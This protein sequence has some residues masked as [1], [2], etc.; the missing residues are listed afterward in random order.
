MNNTE[1]QEIVWRAGRELYRDMPWRESP[2]PYFVLVS[3]LM[4]QQT[5]VARVIP[6]FQEFIQRFPTLSDLARSSLSDVLVL[7]NGLGYNR[8]AK[9]LWQTA[10]EV[11]RRFDGELPDTHDELV[12]LPG[13]GPNT[14]GAILNYAYEIPTPFIETN[15][16]T[17]Y[18]HHFFHDE[19]LVDDKT[20]KE[21]VVST[22]DR[23]HPRAWFWALMDYGAHLK[24]TVGGRID[25]SRHYKKQSP[26]KGSLRE[27]RGMIIR[28]LAVHPLDEA[29]L[30]MAVQADERFA[31]ALRDLERE[32]MIERS[33]NDWRLHAFEG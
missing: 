20:L 6:K 4:L 33:G 32:G 26:L 23:E 15:I 11:A 24:T 27:M 19:A 22:M 16:R 13:I 3:E 14:A 17:V 25:K 29:Q 7:W 10:Q 2:T 21:L 8:R 28:E 5:Q 1:F 18:F 30:K 9:Y 31:T 12:S